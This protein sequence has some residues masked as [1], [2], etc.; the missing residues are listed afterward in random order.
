MIFLGKRISMIIFPLIL[1]LLVLQKSR[2]L[3]TH[4]LVSRRY[5]NVLSVLFILLLLAGIF[6]SKNQQTSKWWQWAEKA[7]SSV[8]SKKALRIVIWT[9]FIVSTIAITASMSSNIYHFPIRCNASDMLPLI[10][11]A[12]QLLLEGRSPFAARYC[13]LQIPCTY[14]PAQITAYM[15]AILLQLDLRFF[16]MLYLLGILLMLFRHLYDSSQKL[17]AF[18][19]YGFLLTS[20]LLS[21]FVLHI[22]LFPYL[23]LIALFFYHI[24][25]RNFGWGALCCGLLLAFRQTFWFSF[26]LIFILYWKEK[27]ATWKR[28]VALGLGGLAFGAAP[29]LFFLPS[30]IINLSSVWGHF[31]ALLKK[32]LFLLHSLGFGYYLFD[33]KKTAQIFFAIILLIIFLAA[34]RYLKLSNFVIFFALVETVFFFTLRLARPEEYYALT[35][36]LAIGF[37]TPLQKK[38]A[39]SCL[40]FVPL[41]IVILT[42]VSLIFLLLPYIANKPRF[43]PGNEK[44][45][46][47]GS[48]RFQAKSYCEVAVMIG[49]KEIWLGKRNLHFSIRCQPKELQKK[50]AICIAINDEILLR[51][52][53]EFAKTNIVLHDVSRHLQVG[54]NVLTI[55]MADSIPFTVT[56]QQF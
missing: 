29:A 45:I 15:P 1:Q 18:L 22:Q 30:F 40:K 47:S 46:A 39:A 43:L 34:I 49:A 5:Y 11:Q 27:P 36:V 26:P 3:M 28:D 6:L 50:P 19:L 52:R 13:P 32:N 33:Y 9:I 42:F 2:F 25:R 12:N 44:T 37:F 21:F 51:Q 20:P 41:T 10:R 17:A 7:F 53:L 35:I 24:V 56:I 48:F 31:Q 23:F 4:W 14:L 16:S 54:A 8:F 55:D 38:N